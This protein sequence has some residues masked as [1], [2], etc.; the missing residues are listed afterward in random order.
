MFKPRKRR[1]YTPMT[2]PDYDEE[3][4]KDQEIKNQDNN[5]KQNKIEEK[6][7]VNK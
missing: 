3:S 5:L 7:D 6:V 2:P 1:L 4:N